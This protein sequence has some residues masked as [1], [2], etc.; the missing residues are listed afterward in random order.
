[1]IFRLA[2]REIRG[3]IN[4]MSQTCGYFG[5]FILSL[6]GGFL[7][8]YISPYAPFAFVG[9]FDLIFAI[10]AIVLGC[11]DILKNDHAIRKRREYEA[12]EALR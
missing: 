5:Q 4:G 12:R 2:D 10:T 9:I 6:S 11:L 3:T 8:D 7:F 1:M